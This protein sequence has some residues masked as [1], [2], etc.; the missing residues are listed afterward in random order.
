MKEWIMHVRLLKYLFVLLFVNI[1][2]SGLSQEVTHKESKDVFLLD[3]LKRN[4]IIF[5]DDTKTP[6]LDKNKKPKK[7]A[8]AQFKELLGFSFTFRF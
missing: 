5:D 3:S 4:E 6:F 2:I 8:R 1:C 7:T